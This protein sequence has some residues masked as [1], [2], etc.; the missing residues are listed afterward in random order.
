[1]QHIT[2]AEWVAFNWMSPGVDTL[3]HVALWRDVM[4]IVPLSR[5]READVMRA[6]VT[7]VQGR[8]RALGR[9]VIHVSLRLRWDGR[10]VHPPVVLVDAPPERVTD[11]YLRMLM[12]SGDSSP[13]QRRALRQRPAGRW[14]PTAE[15]KNILQQV[16]MLVPPL[17][18]P[19]LIVPLTS[20]GSLQISKVPLSSRSVTLA[21]AQ[22]SWAELPLPSAFHGNKHRRHW[23]WEAMALIMGVMHSRKDGKGTP[24]LVDWDGFLGDPHNAVLVQR[25]CVDDTIELSKSPRQMSTQVSKLVK[26]VSGLWPSPVDL[27]KWGLQQ[28]IIL[29][30][31]HARGLGRRVL[32]YVGEKRNADERDGDDHVVDMSAVLRSLD[33][34]A[35]EWDDFAHELMLIGA[36]GAKLNEVWCATKHTYDVLLVAIELIVLT[37]RRQN[38]VVVE[39]IASLVARLVPM[40]LDAVRRRRSGID[41][42]GANGSE[43]GGA[44]DDA[45]DERRPVRRTVTSRRA[46]LLQNRS[47]IRCRRT[48]TM[49]VDPMSSDDDSD[50]PS[51][52][53]NDVCESSSRSSEYRAPKLTC[54]RR[55]VQ[56]ALLAKRPA[57]KRR[58]VHERPAVDRSSRTE[59]IAHSDPAQGSEPPAQEC[60]ADTL[61]PAGISNVDAAGVCRQICFAIA[62]VHILRRLPGWHRVS[63]DAPWVGLFNQVMNP[64]L[65]ANVA[66]YALVELISSLGNADRATRSFPAGHQHDADDFVLE[67]LSQMEAYRMVGADGQPIVGSLVEFVEHVVDTCA[68]CGHASSRP[69][70]QQPVVMLQGCHRR[71]KL[72]TVLVG[73]QSETITRRCTSNVPCQPGHDVEHRSTTFRHMARSPTPGSLLIVRQDPME[74][75]QQ[76]GPDGAQ[77]SMARRRTTVDVVPEVTFQTGRAYFDL[78]GLVDYQGSDTQLAGHDEGHYISW[79]KQPGGSWVFCD[80]NRLVRYGESQVASLLHKRVYR[81]LFYRCNGIRS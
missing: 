53:T 69:P 71:V 17:C 73:E 60:G 74:I 44:G 51:Q 79:V 62:P 13:A 34:G 35:V 24:V 28:R 77:I 49:D 42:A 30:I 63:G 29:M 56:V 80:T 48:S 38:D 2:F 14:V 4:S 70:C 21:Q 33:A 61:L 15:F 41:V 36:V 26:S 68:T 54:K 19:D 64:R 75:V 67:L 55:R 39:R 65:D 27:S 25:P 46:A 7:R 16:V 18:D 47:A 1:M 9:D 76:P 31:F 66:S 43:D 22:G 50:A 72:S 3:P 37:S 6:L 32:T 23:P 12:A 58:Q 45:G 81:L 10:V 20:A 78:V 11:A 57:R 52:D 40:Y 59:R 5:F 8:R